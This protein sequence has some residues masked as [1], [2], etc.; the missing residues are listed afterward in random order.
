MSKIVLVT[1]AS[2]ALGRE[3]VDSLCEAGHKVWACSRRQKSKAPSSCHKKGV[4]YVSLQ[5]GDEKKVESLISS[6]YQQEGRID[7]AFLLAGGFEIGGLS[8]TSSTFMDEQITLN[9]KTAYHVAR[10]VFARMCEQKSGHLCLIGSKSAL[11]PASGGFATAY[12]ISKSMLLALAAILE[13]EG[14]PFGVRT[15]VIVPGIIDTPSNRLAMPEASPEDWVPASAIAEA[16]LLLLDQ[17]T[18]HWRENLIKIYNK[19]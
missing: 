3:V 8:D 5:L 6:I 14:K 4:E 16:L 17:K 2:G 7:A 1:G 18:Q 15:S 13:E 9:F 11:S 12:T 19:S 10:P